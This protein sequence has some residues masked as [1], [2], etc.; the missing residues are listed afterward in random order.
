M[1]P[2]S[3]PQWLGHYSDSQTLVLRLGEL[4]I[5]SVAS[6]SDFAVVSGTIQNK[7]D[8][9]APSKKMWVNLL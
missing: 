2:V 8:A 9:A 1:Y 6:C 3:T 7:L 5:T 4:A